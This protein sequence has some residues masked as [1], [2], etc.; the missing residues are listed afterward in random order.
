MQTHTD[1]WKERDAK[2]SKY[3][4]GVQVEGSWFWYE[5]WLLEVRRHCKNNQ[6]KYKPS[7]T[8]QPEPAE[9]TVA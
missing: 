5:T 1:L 9:G 3:Q 6:E 2:N 4:F 7:S 8:S